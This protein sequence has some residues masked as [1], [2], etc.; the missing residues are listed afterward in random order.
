[1]QINGVLKNLAFTEKYE[2]K[3]KRV[4]FELESF[5]WIDYY[6][7]VNYFVIKKYEIFQAMC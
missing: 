5:K 3:K 6:L 7:T 4:Q 1:M 2:I